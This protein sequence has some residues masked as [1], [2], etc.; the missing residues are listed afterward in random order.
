MVVSQKKAVRKLRR[1]GLRLGLRPKAIAERETSLADYFKVKR[2]GRALAEIVS[3]K[4]IFR[5]RT[6][7]FAEPLGKA[8]I[9]RRVSGWAGGEEQALAWYRSQPIAAFGGL[10]AESL[11]NNGQSGQVMEYL[12]G[13]SVGGFA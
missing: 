6:R 12:D 1:L 3:G 2:A 4:R 8:E 10:T 11:V 13:I 5:R 9:L 7:S